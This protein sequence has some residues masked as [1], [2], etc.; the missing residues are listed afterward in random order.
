[1]SEG[2]KNDILAYVKRYPKRTLVE[3]AEEFG[4][5]AE[6]IAGLLKSLRPTTE[7][8]RATL[9]SRANE[10]VTKV[11]DKADV[12]QIIDV[13]SRTN[14]GV[15]DPIAKGRGDTNVGIMVSVQQG[16]LAAVTVPAIEGETVEED[17]PPG[18]ARKISVGN[19][20]VGQFYRG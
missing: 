14:V 12:D 7:L 11:V 6:T 9:L 16:S 5:T 4:R 20:P 1:M 19:T 8:A 13:L 2:E 3:V 10:L 15:L 18:K 17:P